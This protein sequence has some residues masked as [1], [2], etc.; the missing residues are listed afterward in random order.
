MK[1]LLVLTLIAAACSPAKQTASTGAVPQTPSTPATSLVVDG[2]LFASIYQQKSAE[3][4]ALCFQAYNLAMIKLDQAIERRGERTMAIIT[5]IDETV[6]DNSM[7]QINRSL[8]GKDY[9]SLS[10]AQWIERADADTVP[11][12]P[13]FLKYCASKKVEVFYITNRDE[14]DRNGTIKSLDAF[15]LPNVDDRHLMMRQ[16]SS[17]KEQRRQEIMSAYNVVLFIG[18]N[19]ADFTVD[20]DKKTQEERDIY[21]KKL[22]AEFGSRFI[23]IPNPVYGDWESA[24][25]NNNNNY[26]LREKDSI[27]R[28][29]GKTY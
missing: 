18:D 21:T 1:K 29:S 20:Y 26:S 4:K 16:G 8:Q 22:A 6:L 23:I 15:N 14:K 9:E 24:L 10:W 28:T 13:H 17:S 7:Y 19:L 27:I 12:A 2:K 11:G 25:Y 3:Y 5:D